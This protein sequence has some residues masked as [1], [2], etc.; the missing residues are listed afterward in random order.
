[1]QSAQAFID[2]LKAGGFTYD[3][4]ADKFVE[5]GS[6]DGYLVGRKALGTKIIEQLVTEKTIGA[7]LFSFYSEHQD[8]FDNSLTSFMGGWIEDGIMH[9]D[10]VDY[11]HDRDTALILGAWEEQIAIFNIKT[12]DCVYLNKPAQE[13]A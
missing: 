2:R 11:V 4:R 8:R 12:G 7:I 13:A 9:L 10:V 5:I 3:P 1:M 6:V